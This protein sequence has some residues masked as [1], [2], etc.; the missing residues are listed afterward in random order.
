MPT[1]TDGDGTLWQGN[2]IMDNV[3]PLL[4]RK[5]R[6]SG[7]TMYIEYST[8]C[9]R[10]AKRARTVDDL[11]EKVTE[12]ELKYMQN[13]AGLLKGKSVSILTRGIHRPNRAVVDIA[14]R[15]VNNG[16][17]VIMSA[18]DERTVDSFA[19]SV[20]LK[21]YTKVCSH[22]CEENETL[23]G[24]F[25]KIVTT[26]TKTD[27][28]K[29]GNVYENGINGAGVIAK[30]IGAGCEANICGNDETLMTA[31][32]NLNLLKRVKFIGKPF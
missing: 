31:L 29:G 16:G 24:S 12:A 20:N 8:A 17:L 26:R 25:D 23:I 21:G 1:H 30:A 32:T 3:M 27:A 18:E 11:I 2:Y 7:T 15:S 4:D 5:D 9:H 13:G 6:L 10:A 19:A 22:L 28:Y 14:Y